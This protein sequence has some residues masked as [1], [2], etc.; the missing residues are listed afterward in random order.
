MVALNNL[1][2]ALHPQLGIKTLATAVID[3]A[4]RRLIAQS[5]VP[6]ILNVSWRF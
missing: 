2:E 3:Y 5:L 1:S 6:G 4:G